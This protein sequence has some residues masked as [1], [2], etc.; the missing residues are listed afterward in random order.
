M[1]SCCF[2]SLPAYGYFNP[3][4]FETTGGGGAKRQS[5]LLAT[6]LA[7]TFDVSF[8]VGE[9]GQPR[10]E[11]RAG[12]RLFAA[13]TPNETSTPMAMKSLVDAMR[14]ADADVYVY[15]G[16]PRKAAF[17]GTVAKLLGRDWIYNVSNDADLGRHY[18][19]CSPVVQ[20]A[21]R[22]ALQRSYAV[23]TQTP[24]QQARLQD[25][26]GIESTIIPSGYPPIEESPPTER[27]FVLWVGRLDAEQKRPQKLL[28]C[29]ARLPAVPFRVVGP[30][31]DE[32]APP[33]WDRRVGE[34]DNVDY[35]GPVDPES[36]HEL[37]ARA[38]ALVN[39]SAY[40]GF[41]NTFLEAWRYET[42]VVSLDVDPGRFLDEDCYSGYADGSMDR[43]IAA[44]SE[45]ATKPTKRQSMGRDL[46]S[47]VEEVYHIDTVTTQFGQLL[48][49]LKQ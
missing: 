5:Y 31:P 37:F 4:R 15:R 44:L 9:Y 23:V 39:T 38:I 27:E 36:I 45:L 13:Y 48:A 10:I 19:A 17:I 11:E 28:E 29:A 30:L 18:D 43:L 2:V 24:H 1:R 7:D 46:R 41:P 33:Q 8:I 32:G 49:S 25:R 3:D 16:R 42:P 40:E 26:F 20:R 21:F 34:L 35:L 14:L 12:V 6:G 47:Y 22:W